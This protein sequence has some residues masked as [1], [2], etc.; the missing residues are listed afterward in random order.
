MSQI[1]VTEDLLDNAAAYA[2]QQHNDEWFAVDVSSTGIPSEPGTV[3]V[4]YQGL[5]FEVWL[6]RYW[7]ENQ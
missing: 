4:E 3:I 5:S 6:T 2:A 1:Q 7:H